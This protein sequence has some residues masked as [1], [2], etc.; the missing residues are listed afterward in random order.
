MADEELGDGE[1]ETPLLL[2][3][4]VRRGAVGLWQPSH[5]LG[6][7]RHQIVGSRTEGLDE[8]VR[9]S[10]DWNRLQEILER[11]VGERAIRF[12]AVPFEH[13]APACRARARTSAIE[14]RFADPGFTGDEDDP[15]VTGP[16]FVDA[17]K[18]GFEV[19]IAADEHRADDRLVQ[20]GGR[21]SGQS[22]VTMPPPLA[23][24]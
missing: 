23:A 21:E 7:E 10:R 1:E 9:R 14:T 22:V 2:L 16:R 8:G 24:V 15:P 5:Q 18:H 20:G 3:G 4:V 11:R 13:T 6:N 12:E 19:R 17:P